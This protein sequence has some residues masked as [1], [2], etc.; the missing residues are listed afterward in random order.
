LV[1]EKHADF[2]RDLRQWSDIKLLTVRVDRLRQ[3]HRAGLLCIGDAAHAMSPIGGV[4]IHLAIEDA[5]AAA[6]ILA[7]PLL[8]RAVSESLL[9]KV[10]RRRE[11][12]TRLTN[13]T[14]AAN[15]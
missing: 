11:M 4:G 13:V 3:R 15:G 1:L 12:P 10:Q 14:A 6:N 2:L 5:V 9:H 8:R 7:R